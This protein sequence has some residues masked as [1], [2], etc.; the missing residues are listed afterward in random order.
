M[1]LMSA[2]KWHKGLTK[3]QN[4]LL[5]VKLWQL[6]KVFGGVQVCV[7]GEGG[8]QLSLP[9]DP[10]SDLSFDLPSDLPFDLPFDLHSDLP[11]TLGQ[12]VELSQ[13][14]LQSLQ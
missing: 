11:K 10:H 12:S 4:Q 6:R 9:S 3:Q 13:C 1:A 8:P 7:G 2:L 14:L 5:I